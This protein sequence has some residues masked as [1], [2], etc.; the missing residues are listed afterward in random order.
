MNKF[1]VK[2]KMPIILLAALLLCVAVCVAIYF[3]LNGY[4]QYDIKGH[5][6]IC[7]YTLEGYN[8]Y[9]L[10]GQPAAV[11]SIGEIPIAFS[12]VPW[13]CVFGSVFYGGFLPFEMACIYI[14]VMH[15]VA[16]AALL[17]VFYR[18]FRS[19]FSLIHMVVILLIPVAHFSFMYSVHYGNAGGIICCLLMIAFLIGEKHP[20]IA[21]VLLGFAMMKPQISAIICLVYLFEKKFKT[22]FVAAGIVVAGWAST[23][24]ATSTNPVDLLVQTFNS[25]TAADTQYLGLLNNLKYFGVDSGII[26]LMN[27]AIGCLYVAA[28][29]FYLKKNDIGSG[30]SYFV[31]V[32]ACVASTF[33]VYKNGTDYMIIAFAVF[34]LALLC[35][36]KDLNI[37]ELL[38]AIFSIG[39]LEMSRCFVYFG[40]TL[41][42][43]NLFVRDLFKSFDGLVVAIIG[44]ILCKLWV[45]YKEEKCLL[46]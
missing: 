12:T 42:K 23:C 25:G 11:D 2:N 20:C 5:W 34:F 28:L 18:K 21:G 44:V 16:L 32:P 24:F 37:K 39:W 45:K 3:Y 13:S 4:T 6:K 33:W 31:Y 22:L 30:G 26:L 14:Y 27:V 46:K 35:M 8:P 40:I 38:V 41:F 1:S 19:E 29:Y 17:F 9:L 43:D 7:R 36:K 10:I 15:F